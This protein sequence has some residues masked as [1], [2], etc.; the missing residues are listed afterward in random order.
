MT[1]ICLRHVNV[2]E[3][4]CKVLEHPLDYEEHMV[5]YQFRALPKRGGTEE[6]WVA[7]TKE[8]I[9]QWIELL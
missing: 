5:R 6:E 4:H 7:R 8:Y 9:E 1:A 2:K 3:A